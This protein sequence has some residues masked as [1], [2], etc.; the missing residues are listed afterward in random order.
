MSIYARSKSFS[1]IKL[2]LLFLSI[3]LLFLT[4]LLFYYVPHVTAQS[5]CPDRNS[6]CLFYEEL[7]PLNPL[8]PDKFLL[9]I[10]NKNLRVGINYTPYEQLDSQGYSLGNRGGGNI[11][12]LYDKRTDPSK[13]MVAEVE[14]CDVK[15]CGPNNPAPGT[16]FGPGTALQMAGI[17]GLGSTS[18]HDDYNHTAGKAD[19]AEGDNG[20]YGRLVEKVGP[21]RDENNGNVSVA[22]TYIV[23]SHVIL[24]ADASHPQPYRPDDY[25]VVKTWLVHE[26]GQID[27]Q[28]T[29]KFLRDFHGVS[30][31][32]CL[33]DQPE[34]V[35]EPTVNFAFNR[36]YGWTTAKAIRHSTGK[37]ICSTIDANGV[38]NPLD[39]PTNEFNEQIIHRNIDVPQDR[40]YQLLHAQSF[41]LFGQPSGSAVQVTVN[42]G[43]GGFENAP[44]GTGLF[45]YGL[46]KL[47]NA[48]SSGNPGMG[49]LFTNVGNPSVE[50]S[51]F[52]SAAHGYALRFY[53]W[54]GGAPP[55]RSRF[56]TDINANDTYTDSFT[57][58]M[59]AN[60]PAEIM[61]LS[62]DS[63]GMQSFG[64]T[65]K[66]V[67]SISAD[68][69]FVAY[70][71][72]ASDL[73]PAD[74]DSNSDVF[75]K[76][77]VT[78]ETEL[79]SRATGADG[80]KSN[81]WSTSPSISDDGRFVAFISSGNNLL[82]GN[83]DSNNS[84]DVFVRDRTTN[85]TRLISVG[86]NG[87]GNGDSYY[88]SISANGRYIVFS[89]MAG[90]LLVDPGAD[91]NNSWD[92]FRKEITDAN[93]NLI[94]NGQILRAS[95][96][97]QGNEGVSSSGS[98]SSGY[99]N[100]VSNDGQFVAF[101]SYA[102][103]LLGYD[104]NGAPIDTNQDWDV[105]RKDMVSG[106]LIRA[107][108][109]SSGAQSDSWNFWPIISDDGSKIAFLSKAG[110]LTS[111][112]VSQCPD[113]NDPNHPNC[114]NVFIRDLTR[115]ATVLVSSDWSGTYGGGNQHSFS[116]SI[117]NDGNIVAFWSLASNLTSDDTNDVYDTFMKNM[118]TGKIVRVS[119][120]SD[121]TENKGD[122][123]KPAL[124]SE[125]THIAFVSDAS[126]LVSNDSNGMTDLFYKEVNATR[127]GNVNSPTLMSNSGSEQSSGGSS[128][129]ADVTYNGAYIAFSS[130]ATNLLGTNPDGSLVDN[131][132]ARD[133]FLKDVSTGS[134]LRM[135]SSA[136]GEAALYIPSDI[137]PKSDNPSVSDDG[138]LVAFESDANNLIGYKTD[139]SVADDNSQKDVFVKGQNGS[140]IRV[141]TAPNGAGGNG[142]SESPT[143]SS[144]GKY[145]AFRS[146]A[147]NLIIDASGNSRDTNNFPDIFVK[148]V[149]NE[150]GELIDN[151]E[152]VR[153]STKASGAHANNNSLLPTISWDGTYVAFTSYASDLVPNDD[154]T[155]D[156]YRKMVIVNGQL[157]ENGPIDLVSRNSA[158]YGSAKGTAVSIDPS[159]SGD[160]RYVAFTSDAS[161]LLGP[162][163]DVNSARDVFVKDILTGNVI[164]ASADW[165]GDPSI[166]TT[167]N[168][169]SSPSISGD[170]R[171]VT[172]QSSAWNIFPYTTNPQSNVFVKDN[173]TG[174]IKSL[175]VDYSGRSGGNS[176]TLPRISSDGRYIVFQ[177]LAP[178]LVSNDTNGLQDTFMATNY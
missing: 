133:V 77:T 139:G 45:N 72:D 130:N 47:R 102:D 141:S 12:K 75:V 38:V 171:Y 13:N 90:N 23:S 89:S 134:M 168:M 62:T 60:D 98:S 35:S 65:D 6:D 69:E 67:P 74:Q 173:Q 63:S 55:G 170:G 57:I 9:E 113:S 117:S 114:S 163:N 71:S 49:D 94:S 84:V 176:S 53:T 80:I 16:G 160:G 34:C 19:A 152:L 30:G 18:I 121:L 161:N 119:N 78:G 106:Q 33:N 165:K 147:S 148:R 52:S 14:A 59:L 143:I 26:D 61:R 29:R 3:G 116:P 87:P 36:D 40:D 28:V 44:N 85:E 156:I 31:G 2:H 64:N 158:Q 24:P 107:S 175:A 7:N 150:N 153:V 93:G 110:N 154:Y 15:D 39:G 137:V 166:S 162:G 32:Q 172:F 22:L 68:G 99:Y 8:S 20:A 50:F 27:Y 112:T 129:K 157:V 91:T 58:R 167:S 56:S 151:G 128:S 135:S 138:Q 97:S 95:T 178:N 120:G 105:F 177:S 103:N 159:I 83:S 124:S 127:P 136:T 46:N 88:P 104:V 66:I 21:T 149:R 146:A 42:E 100:S 81:G 48:D 125:G 43:S 79:I 17:G 101:V 126:G 25:E 111:D 108:V 145:V 51:N 1:S 76:N 174:A 4:I 10:E 142:A 70:V 155:G 123:G 169:C 118:T 11:Y 140:I 144:D 164:L 115:N 37:D 131:N 73:N 109:S 86:T 54:W 41:V 82:D 5:S 122:A 96:D 132:N 92:I